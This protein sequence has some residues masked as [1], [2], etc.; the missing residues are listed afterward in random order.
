MQN[1]GK[2]I[3][4]KKRPFFAVNLGRRIGFLVGKL[5]WKDYVRS[6]SIEGYTQVEA[7]SCL[8]YII[9]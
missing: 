8:A 7:I 3:H 5:I 9:A 1:E 2:L 6:S 4:C